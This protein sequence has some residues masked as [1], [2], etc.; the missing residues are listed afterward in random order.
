MQVLTGGP[1]SGLTDAQVRALLTSSSSLTVDFGLDLLDF[2]LIVTDDLTNYLEGGS[3]SRVMARVIHGECE[4]RLGTALQWGTSLVRPWQS[5]SAEGV[6]AR[7]DLG[8]FSLT[9]PNRVLGTSVPSYAVHGQD[10]TYLL[11]RSVGDSYSAPQGA[12]YLN[13][14]RSV[15]A[16]A[17]LT[18]VALDGQ[19]Q[20]A[21]LPKERVWPFMDSQGG[22][23]STT[24]LAIANDL[25]AAIG[26][27]G[28]YADP[29][30]GYF[31]SEPYANPTSRR[32]EFTFTASGDD[33]MIDEDRTE[34]ADTWKTTNR[35]IFLQANRPV[36]APA[37]SPGDGKYI[38][39][40]TNEGPTSI[41]ARNGFVW[42][43]TIE[44]DAADQATL[45][46]QG[47]IKVAAARRTARVLEFE[48]SP[49][50]A[51][52]HYDVLLIDDP[53]LGAP[54]TVQASSWSLDLSGKNTK[55]TAEAIV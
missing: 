11:N 13:E 23:G 50:P 17:G 54:V 9:T 16:R 40:N 19:A 49:F 28:L 2:D 34:T 22:S 31:R 15:I 3:V 33:S 26:Y 47:A 1:R 6:T 14:V 30:T 53:E 25:L 45:E 48:T 21:T 32:P 51:A 52:G 18:G 44:I 43:E 20:A 37:P 41:E 35:W 36:G 12:S 42:A 38:V 7:F 27:R 8:V 4:L 55:W 29:A 24:W 39:D 10:R 5:L 46:Q